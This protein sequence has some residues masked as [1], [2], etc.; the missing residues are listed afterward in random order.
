MILEG[1]Q[2]EGKDIFEGR[3]T[4]ISVADMAIAIADEIEQQ[5]LVWKHW[6]AWADI[7]EDLPAPSYLK[8]DTVDGGSP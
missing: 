3:L 7:S 2:Q 6:S 1:P 8:L 4:G 5:K